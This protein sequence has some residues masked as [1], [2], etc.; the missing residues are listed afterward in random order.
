MEAKRRLLQRA[1]D[2]EGL[3]GEEEALNGPRKENP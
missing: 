3:A 2:A 1:M